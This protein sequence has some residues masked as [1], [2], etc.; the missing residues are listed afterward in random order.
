MKRILSVFLAA[1]LMLSILASCAEQTPNEPPSTGTPSSAVEEPSTGQASETEPET[2]APAAEE[3]ATSKYEYEYVAP[4]DGSFTICGIPLSEYSLVLYFPTSSDYS[5][6]ERKL[7]VNPLKDSISSATGTDWDIKVIKN[8]KYDTQKWAEHEILLG[9]NFHRDGMPETDMQKNY[10]GVTADGTVY[11]STPSPMMYPHL[12]RLFLEEFFGVPYASGA[13]SAGCAIQECYREI[14][15]FDIEALK[16][17]G[18]ELVFEDNFDGDEID[19][20]RWALSEEVVGYK[21]N[22]CY[23]DM[24]LENGDLVFLG[25]ETEID[26]VKAWRGGEVCVREPYLYGYIEARIKV[27]YCES[28]ANTEYWSAFWIYEPGVHTDEISQ[29]GK[30]GVELDIVENWGPDHTSSCVWVAGAE[31]TEGLSDELYEVHNMGFNYP[32]EYHVYS[33]LWDENY[34]QIFVDGILIA[35]SDFYS[36]T[37]SIPEHIILSLIAKGDKH[38]QEMEMRTD[39]VRIWQ[40]PA[41]QD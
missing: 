4:E 29:G 27:N 35:Y 23:D 7:V 18:Y 21:A 10:Y 12:F 22:I 14:P 33:V 39:Y 40:K 6:M 28:R 2:E 25:R 20:N 38:T 16:A 31:G 5:Y 36:G 11:F 41:A 17:D 24:F 30:Y 34:Y 15:R 32:E 1:L 9:S 3:P 8:E 19:W 13:A 37:S 26:G